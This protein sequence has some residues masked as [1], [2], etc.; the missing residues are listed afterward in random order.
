L[1]FVATTNNIKYTDLK[2]IGLGSE[3]VPMYCGVVDMLEKIYSRTI[4]LTD[5][6]TNKPE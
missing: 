1:N 5:P 3:S 6:I 2:S 4:N